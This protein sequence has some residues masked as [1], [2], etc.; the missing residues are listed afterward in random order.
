MNTFLT[1]VSLFFFSVETPSNFTVETVIQAMEN[2]DFTFVE[3]AL[4]K[5]GL[6]PN[7]FFEGKSLLVHAVM[8][9]KA[10]MVRLL[11]V[12]GAHLYMASEEGMIP[13]D[14]AIKYQKIHAQAELIVITS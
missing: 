1:L 4:T 12:K 6:S 13:M 3:E 11:I 7:A 8:L 5:G 2:E 9:D 10:E 14:Y